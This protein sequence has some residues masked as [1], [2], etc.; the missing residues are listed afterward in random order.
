MARHFI[1]MWICCVQW[2]PQRPWACATESTFPWESCATVGWDV[3]KQGCHNALRRSSS[4]ISISSAF[5]NGHGSLCNGTEMAKT[6]ARSVQ[7]QKSWSGTWSCSRMMAHASLQSFQGVLERFVQQVVVD[8]SNHVPGF[9]VCLQMHDAAI[10]ESC[11]KVYVLDFWVLISVL[12][13]L[14]RGSHPGVQRQAAGGIGATCQRSLGSAR[15]SSALG[16]QVAPKEYYLLFPRS[17]FLGTFGTLRAKTSSLYPLL[18]DMKP[19]ETIE[20]SRLVTLL[21]S[22]RRM[23]CF[24]MGRQNSTDAKMRHETMIH[25]TK[26]TCLRVVLES[27]IIQ[28]Y[29][30]ASGR[31]HTQFEHLHRDAT[32][33]THKRHDYDRIW[34]MGIIFINH[35]VHLGASN[36]QSHGDCT[37]SISAGQCC[38]AKL[39]CF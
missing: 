25:L 16:C 1:C 14:L 24:F 3:T 9:I 32:I 35:L 18:Q 7:M 37:S 13:K 27:W 11:L 17:T 31:E 2:L 21:H 22:E 36:P 28:K 26:E 15:L 23:P 34:I 33:G 29:E 10:F 30:A 20:F 38:S 4:R 39:W 6:H 19:T 12:R 5:R 8:Q